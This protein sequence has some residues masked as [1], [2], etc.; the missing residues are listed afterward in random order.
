LWKEKLSDIASDYYA[1]LQQAFAQGPPPQLARVVDVLFTAYQRHAH[2]YALGNGACAALAAHMACDLG[3]TVTVGSGQNGTTKSGRLRV[4]SLADNSALVTADAND[5]SYDDVFVEQL[6][7]QV[8]NGDL[9][10]ALS[11]SGTSRNVL[12]AVE[13][14]NN[15]GATTIGFTGSAG[16][17]MAL[18]AQCDIAV[19]SPAVQM[20]QIEDMHVTFHHIITLMLRRRIGEHLAGPGAHQVN[21]H[22]MASIKH[23]VCTMPDDG[24][25][26]ASPGT[27]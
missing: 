26:H 16:S 25:Q 23:P 2:V 11:A 22:S 8:D 15:C 17:A 21:G 14:A 27:C 12:R 3:R 20:E 7:C 1:S 13:Y 24:R 19:R 4:T 10:I 9:V 5:I 18:V 6:K